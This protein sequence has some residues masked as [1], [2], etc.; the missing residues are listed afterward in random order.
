M[1]REGEDA[2]LWI[3]ELQGDFKK[4]Q[5]AVSREVTPDG[6]VTLKKTNRLVT[7]QPTAMSDLQTC[8]SRIED[9]PRKQQP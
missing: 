4:N 8:R 2:H 9:A 1:S 6:Y 7:C 3:Q 5:Q